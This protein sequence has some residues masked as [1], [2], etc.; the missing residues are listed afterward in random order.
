MIKSQKVPLAF[1]PYWIRVKNVSNFNKVIIL[2]SKGNI[3]LSKAGVA[4]LFSKW[5]KF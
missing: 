3:I 5:A 1:F 4:N 2:K